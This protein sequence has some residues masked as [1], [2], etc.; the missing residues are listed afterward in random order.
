VDFVHLLKP[1]ERE[2]DGQMMRVLTSVFDLSGDITFLKVRSEFYQD[3]H[4]VLLVFDVC[5][6]QSFDRLE[7]WLSE[8]SKFGNGKSIVTCVVCGNKSDLSAQ[9][10]V[11]AREAKTWASSK[12]QVGLE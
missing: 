12:G 5:S 7:L 10:V 9:R 8:A 1:R 4:G 2:K 3:F 11:S 6:R